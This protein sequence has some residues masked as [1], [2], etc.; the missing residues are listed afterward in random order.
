MND[1][2]TLLLVALIKFALV[3][4][5]IGWIPALIAKSKGRSFVP[6]WFYGGGLFLIALI[7]S[8]C[9]KSRDPETDEQ[10]DPKT[11][12]PSPITRTTTWK[13][14]CGEINL[15]MATACRICDCS[16]VCESVRNPV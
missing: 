11:R 3:M 2:G 16:R 7:H 6:W 10:E 14:N 15:A 8:L 1:P 5:F 13:C 12:R 9:I 4:L